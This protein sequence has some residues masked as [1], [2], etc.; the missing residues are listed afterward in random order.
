MTTFVWLEVSCTRGIPVGF[1]SK[2]VLLFYDVLIVKL[3]IGKGALKVFWRSYVVCNKRN[4]T[5]E[6]M[7]IFLQWKFFGSCFNFSPLAFGEAAITSTVWCDKDPIVSFFETSKIFIYYYYCCEYAANSIG[8]LLC[9]FIRPGLAPTFVV[10][11]WPWLYA[12]KKLTIHS[13]NSE[14]RMQYDHGLLL[15]NYIRL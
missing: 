4:T 11:S 9:W 2:Y 7:C 8:L 3:G 13:T 6:R 15:Y 10:V 14:L 12:C 1:N 5:E